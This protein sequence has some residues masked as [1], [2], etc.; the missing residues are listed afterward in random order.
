[1]ADLPVAEQKD[2]LQK[3]LQDG[4]KATVANAA[5]IARGKTVSERVSRPSLATLKG[6]LESENKADIPDECK[7]LLNWIVGNIQTATAVK[8]LDWL[9]VEA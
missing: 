1:L 8:K 7:T 6:L 9:E 3:L 4:G 2:S 5:K